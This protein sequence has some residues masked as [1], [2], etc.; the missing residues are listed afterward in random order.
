MAP[1]VSPGLDMSPT[2]GGAREA[3]TSYML[4]GAEDNNNFSAGAINI[5]PP[6]E[7]VEDFA[8]LTNS[9][10]AQYGRGAGALVTANQKSGTNGFHGVRS[11][12]RRVGK[13]CRSRWSP[14][15]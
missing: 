7:S 11:E 6:L 9:M 13:E 15:H 5:N 14:Y 3:G 12:E 1:S 2:S 4:N 10:G 8:I